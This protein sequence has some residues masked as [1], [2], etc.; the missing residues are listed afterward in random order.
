MPYIALNTTQKLTAQQKEKVKAELGRLITIIPTKTEAGLMV[1]F[2]ESR[3]MYIGG[4]EITG[5][6]VELRLFHQSEME[7]KKKFVEEV[8]KM[9]SKELGISTDDIKLNVMEL[10]TWGTGGI[11]RT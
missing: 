5:A 7:A 10:D 4:K 2:S 3:T 9:L 6:F 11:L 8:F 1:D